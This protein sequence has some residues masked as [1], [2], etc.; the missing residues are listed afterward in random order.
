M[1]F[2]ATYFTKY[3]RPSVRVVRT[4]FCL[5]TWPETSYVTAAA[6]IMK[7]KIV[8]AHQTYKNV[9]IAV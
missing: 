6:R 9:E 7:A 8:F 2:T 5:H 3:L 4:V 1:L